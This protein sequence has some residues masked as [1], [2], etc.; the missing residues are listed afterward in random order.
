[1]VVEEGEQR[2]IVRAGEL[3]VAEH[4]RALQPGSC[5]VQPEH[6]AAFWKLCLPPGQE[7]PPAGSAWQVQFQDGVV[8]RPLSDYEEA[9]LWAEGNRCA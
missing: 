7:A 6:V 2:V 1:V 9:A 3:I 4:R 8:R 5:V